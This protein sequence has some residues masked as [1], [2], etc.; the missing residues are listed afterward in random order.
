MARAARMISSPRAR[1][2]PTKSSN[3]AS[4]MASAR[5]PAR[6][7]LSSNSDNSTVVNRMAPAM[8]W[9]CRNVWPGPLGNLAAC[10]AETSMK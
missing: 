8:V 7:I 3:S 5:S 4:S 9:R 10:A 2:S 1:T 6:A